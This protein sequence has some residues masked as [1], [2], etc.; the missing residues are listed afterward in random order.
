M[1][2][3]FSLTL[4]LFLIMDP[5]G[6]VK[7]FLAI[8]DG[9]PHR[10]QRF[11]IAREMLMALV[12]M[13]VFSLLGEYIS[14]AF[15]VNM[16]TIFISAGIILFLT[17][18]RI[19]FPKDEHLPRVLGNEPFLVPLAVPMIASP[20][21]LA[22]IMLFSQA[23]P[24]ILPMINSILIA[25][26]IS[27]VLLIFSRPLKRLLTQNGLLAI[28]RLMGMVLVLIAVQRFL[29]GIVLFVAERR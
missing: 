15:Q 18:I 29:E 20:A 4:T 13:L 12:A 24:C 6:K 2:S 7:Q 22:T 16:V 11:V 28:E 23:E 8:L 9:I 19:L 14:A 26:A 17:A 21:L 27:S 25:W 10:R 5:L 1:M 3:L